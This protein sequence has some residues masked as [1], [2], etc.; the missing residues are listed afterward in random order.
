[1]ERGEDELGAKEKCS[2]CNGAIE[3]LFNPMA[4]WKIKGSLCGDCYSKKLH[5][6]YPGDHV[7]VNKE[8]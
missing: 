1:M 6:F 5:E 4:E 8:E 3:L 2:I 7:R